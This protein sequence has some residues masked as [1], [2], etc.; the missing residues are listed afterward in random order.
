VRAAEPAPIYRAIEP[1]TP[2]PELPPRNFDTGT[3]C[4]WWRVCNLWRGS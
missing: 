1:A 3:E 4:G 2:A